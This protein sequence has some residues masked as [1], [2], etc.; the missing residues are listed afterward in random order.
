[1]RGEGGGR[2]PANYLKFID[3]VFGPEPNTIEVCSNK[4]HGLNNGS[5]CFTVDINP[6]HKPD[7]VVDGQTLEGIS[8]IIA[9]QD[10]DV[11]LH[12][13]KKLQKKCITQSCKCVQIT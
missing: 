9:F 12:T 1:M 10:G 11:I 5:N 6:E 7:S 8:K 2:Y 13:M 3:N 4:I